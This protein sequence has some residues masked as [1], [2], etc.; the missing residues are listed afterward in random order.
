MD[1][2]GSAAGDKEVEG[3]DQGMIADSDFGPPVQ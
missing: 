2:T 1:G 3:Q